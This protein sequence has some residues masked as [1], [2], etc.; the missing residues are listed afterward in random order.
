MWVRSVAL[1]RLLV[2]AII[3]T[4]CYRSHKMGT[5][6][7]NL[8]CRL[9]FVLII[10]AFTQFSSAQLSSGGGLPS[11]S[12]SKLVVAESGRVFVLD[13]K[14]GGAVYML[15]EDLSTVMMSPSNTSTI[16]RGIVLSV[17]EDRLV[18]CWTPS[19]EENAFCTIHDS[20]T[21]TEL[22]RAR[23]T[24]SELNIVTPSSSSY[25]VSRGFVEGGE[26]FFVATSGADG[27]GGAN[28]LYHG[29]YHFSDGSS[30]RD[31]DSP[32]IE[33]SSSGFIRTYRGGARVGNFVYLVGS[34]ETASDAVRIVRL[35]D[36]SEWDSWYEIRLFCGQSPTLIVDEFDNALISTNFL[37]V[38]DG[39]DE[40]TLVVSVFASDRDETNICSFPISAIDSA[41]NVT[42]TTCTSTNIDLS[43]IWTLELQ[44]CVSGE[45]IVS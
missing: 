16:P 10:I 34:D 21:L 39:I 14:S 41:A 38:E 32:L 40:P 31:L 28:R 43:P 1:V 17:E 2:F 3:H 8:N 30:A 23:L 6:V 45:S 18:I 5:Y 7:Y 11:G 44:Q 4:L 22:A 42:F 15:S 20:S 19:S 13:E 27:S 25:S 9:L 36:G 33:V 35:C 12:L 37:L 24:P 29:E 26:T